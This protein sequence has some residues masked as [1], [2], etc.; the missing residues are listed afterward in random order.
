[1]AEVWN[2]LETEKLPTIDEDIP[3]KE[4]DFWA[5]KVIVIEETAFLYLNMQLSWRGEELYFSVY[6]KKHQTIK[7]INKESCHCNSVFKAV[8]TGVFTCLA[9]ALPIKAK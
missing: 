6:S 5:K 8:P 9:A 7:C 2:P 1:M 3:A 4:W